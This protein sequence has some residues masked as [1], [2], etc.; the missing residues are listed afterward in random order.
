MLRRLSILLATLLAAAPAAAERNQP[1]PGAVPEKGIQPPAG[2]VSYTAIVDSDGTLVRG[3]GATSATS[4][5]AGSYEVVF[6]T[7][8]TGCAFVATIGIA[9]GDGSVPAGYISVVGRAGNASAI[10]VETR[11]LNGALS[12]VPFHVDVGC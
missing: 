12:T 9:N 6:V 4:F 1:V 3:K 8:V 10:Y 2:S 5:G 11:D 7:D